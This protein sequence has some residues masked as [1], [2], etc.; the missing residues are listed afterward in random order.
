M[1][2]LLMSWLGVTGTIVTMGAAADTW[3]VEDVRIKLSESLATQFRSNPAKWFHSVETAFTAIFDYF[4]KWRRPELSRIIWRGI[5]LTYLILILARI[6]LRTFEIQVPA[7]E[8]ILV[9]AFVIAIGLT[10]ILQVDFNLLLR[11]ETYSDTPL[12]ILIRNKQFAMSVIMATLSVTLYTF[13]SIMTAHGMGMTFKNIAAITFGSGIGVPAVVAISRVNDKY[14]PVSPLRA[15]ASSMIFI[16]LLAL[17]FPSAANSFV[18]D[19]EKV[20]PLILATVAFNI[21]GDAISLLE[22]RWVLTLS[23]GLPILGILG[24]LIA[25]LLLSGL[26]YLVLPGISNVNWVN[27]ISAIKFQGSEPWIG[28]LFWST[29]FTSFL[30]YLFVIAVLLLRLIAPLVKFVN[31]LDD[32]FALYQH[33]VRLIT[34]AMIFVE[35]VGFVIYGLLCRPI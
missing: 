6:V 14:M 18:V 3:L 30:F 1:F 32:W 28:I 2:S 10:L 21:F 7:M 29:F 15:I 26:I 8:K 19:F 16:G 17:M 23:R 5:L 13:A 4:Y 9:I 11:R 20:G 25:D 34:V 12:R 24:V 31:K 22:T 35:T 27:L 33:P